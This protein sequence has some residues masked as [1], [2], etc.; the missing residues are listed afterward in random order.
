M[1]MITTVFGFAMSATFIF[2]VF[3]RFICRKIRGNDPRSV[4]ESQTISERVRSINGLQPFVID[5]LPVTEFDN[6]AFCSK[7][8]AQCSICLGEYKDREKLRMLPTCG[9]NF[10]LTCID[11]WLQR[12]STCPICRLSL[13]G[14]SEARSTMS[15]TTFGGALQTVDTPD[16]VRDHSSE[17]LRSP[18]SSS[19]GEHNHEH[20]GSVPRNLESEIAREAETGHH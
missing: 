17:Q 9:H 2:L 13:H 10:H 3:T 1:N 6:E 11:I 18:E 19:H 7:E 8:E 16:V 15:S 5:A 14:S 4:F 20:R 12:Q